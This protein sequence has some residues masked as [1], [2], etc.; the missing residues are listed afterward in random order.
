MVELREINKTVFTNAAGLKVHPDQMKFVCEDL[1]EYVRSWREDPQ[2]LC[3]SIES[4]DKPIGFFALDFNLDRHTAYVPA[5]EDF[6]VLRCFFIDE[7]SQG[8]GFAREALARI[9]ALVR[10]SHPTIE[11]IYLTVNEKNPTAF[12]LYERGGFVGLEKRYLGGAAGP[13]HVMVLEL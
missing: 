3:Y 1:N 2:H 4:K 8:Q 7:R 6:C 5:A 9:P 10:N 11:K 13:Q 12:K